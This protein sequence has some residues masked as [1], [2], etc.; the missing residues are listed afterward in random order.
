[1]PVSEK[2]ITFFRRLY[3][4]RRDKETTL[5]DSQIQYVMRLVT[6][7][8][9]DYDDQFEPRMIS[10]MLEKESHIESNYSPAQAVERIAIVTFNMK[11]KSTATE[12]WSLSTMMAMDHWVEILKRHHP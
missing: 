9:N 8:I 3:A 6:S 10:M 5:T 4:L 12:G 11:N 1:M 2:Q 7:R